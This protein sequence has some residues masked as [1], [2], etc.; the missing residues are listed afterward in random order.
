MDAF[1]DLTCEGILKLIEEGANVNEKDEYEYTPL[2]YACRNDYKNVVS[3]LLEKG[4]NVNEKSKCGYTPLH[5][6][7]Y[8]GYGRIV[9][10]LLEKGANVSEKN[11]GGR[12]PLDYAYWSGRTNIIEILLD[13]GTEV[14]YNEEGK[15]VY[16]MDQI[17]Y[18]CRDKMKKFFDNYIPKSSY[19]KPAK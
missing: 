6:A 12:T 13:N 8:N 11:N 18:R 5:C 3:I 16:D 2:Y 1:Q 19:F 17:F 14:E 4:A 9:S 7:C 15:I 10:I